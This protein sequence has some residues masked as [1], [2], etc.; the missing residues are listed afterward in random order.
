MM[1]KVSKE[2]DYDYWFNF[3]SNGEKRTHSEEGK[4]WKSNNRYYHFDTRGVMVYQWFQTNTESE[5]SASNWSYFS[6]PEDGAKVVKGWFKVVAPTEDNSF[7]ETEATFA[8][9]DSDDESERWYYNDGNDEGLIEG[10][11]KK[12]KGKYYGFWPD[13]DG[14]NKGGRMLIGLCALTM[15]DADRF[16]D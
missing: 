3:K 1:M 10:Q 14:E 5:A 7:L 2:D 6:S 16:E 12:I 4:T 13:D 11:I 15:N 9:K 8:K